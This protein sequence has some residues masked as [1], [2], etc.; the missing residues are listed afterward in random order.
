MTAFMVLYGIFSILAGIIV[1]K[2]IYGSEDVKDI[3][4]WQ[5]YLLAVGAFIVTVICWPF[6]FL[7]EAHKQVF[8][9]HK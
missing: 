3:L 2:G 5:K 7:K 6:F 4:P 1:S 8:S 9:N